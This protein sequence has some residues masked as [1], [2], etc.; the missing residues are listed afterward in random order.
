M[1]QYHPID[2][3]DNK[4]HEEP[5]SGCWLWGGAING[6]GY[7]TTKFNGKTASTHRV[8]YQ[9]H[10][11]E[12]ETG[13]QLDH[14]CRNRACCNPSHLEAVTA[15]ENTLR[16]ETPAAKNAAKTHCP[17]GHAYDDENTYVSP[18]GGRGC[19]ACRRVSSL[20]C[21]HRKKAAL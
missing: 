16:G 11:G 10:V 20:A 3:I 1:N 17:N 2:R 8:M 6:G 7:G 15:A 19:R 18:D 4:V 9:H 21:Y 12:I 5:N 13:L 14:L